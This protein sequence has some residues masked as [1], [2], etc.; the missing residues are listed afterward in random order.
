MKLTTKTGKTLGETEIG[1]DGKHRLTNAKGKFLGEYDPA[2]DQT[3]NAVG[4]LVGGGNWLSALLALSA[5][6]KKRVKSN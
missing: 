6:R 2:N 3:T 4:K 1:R 5:K